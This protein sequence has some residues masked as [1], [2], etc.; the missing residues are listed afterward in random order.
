MAVAFLGDGMSARN[1]PWPWYA[2]LTKTGREKNATL[3]L[4]NSGFEC[5]LPVSKSRRRWSDRV[6]EIDVPLFP[7][8]LF[9]RMNPNDRLPVLITPGVVQIVGRGK[10]PIP[11]E[12][13]EIG[14]IKRVASSGL[15]AMPW[16]YLQVG[17]TARIEEGPLQGLSGIVV[18]IKSGLKLVLSVQLLQRSIAV[19]IDR[20]WIRAT[21]AAGTAEHQNAAQVLNLAAV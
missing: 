17:Q 21:H 1:H 18:K 16:P 2:I 9:C 7:G 6:K 4:E 8:Y 14:A 12:E 3:L 11:I 20:D 15:P 5:Y 19:E 13:H 10:T